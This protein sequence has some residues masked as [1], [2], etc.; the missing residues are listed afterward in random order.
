MAL[1]DGLLDDPLI[2][3][4]FSDEGLIEQLAMRSGRASLWLPDELG[5]LMAQMDRKPALKEALLQVYDG[6]S[7]D[8]ARHSKRVKG[9]PT[10]HED[11]DRIRDPHLSVLGLATPE[12]FDQIN[13]GD[14]VSGLIPR[15][16]LIYPQQRPPRMS[17]E[18]SDVSLDDEAGEL[19]SYLREL[20]VWSAISRDAGTI[21]VSIGAAAL[22]TLDDVG[23]HFEETRDR[24]SVQARLP[25]MAI[26]LAMLSALGEQVPSVPR[27]V[28]EQ[29]DAQRAAETVIRWGADAVRFA[30]E[31]GGLDKQE[32]KA[33]Q[34]I[35]KALL[36]IRE[37][38][39]TSRTE[40]SRHMRISS[41]DLDDT[42]RTMLDRGDL[43]EQDKPTGGRPAKTWSTK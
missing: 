39:E 33:Q 4:K 34:R 25:A 10:T 32:R 24:Q 3:D 13:T 38:G 35:D 29:R 14:V 27:V 43:V 23:R 2:P 16:A 31:I 37:N 40:L 1:L 42:V 28:I 30:S 15:F 26:K 18:V 17:L 8:Y 11:H 20:S 12:V 5:Q 19:R 21:D 7:Y 6:K 9:S 22:G 41:R 36:F